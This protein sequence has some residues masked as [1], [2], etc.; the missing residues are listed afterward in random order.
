[1]Y[2]IVIVGA[3]FAGLST[4]KALAPL[5][6]ASTE[7][8]L[9]LISAR[10]YFYYL[11]ASCRMLVTSE[12]HLEDAVLMP[13]PAEKYNTGNKKLIIASVTRIVEEPKENATGG[14]GGY[15]HLD[16]GEK[17]EY[18]VLALAPGSLWDSEGPCALP[19]GRK[20][21]LDAVGGWRARF[22]G[23]KEVVIIGGGAVG[24]GAYLFP[25]GSRVN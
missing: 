1:M 23:A 17:V 14:A 5:V 6:D 25:P 2:N 7:Y 11:P 9:I 24:L 19:F 10:P 16:N 20:E 8:N 4:W 13:L 3:G 12:G 21:A 18:A 22:E 15:V